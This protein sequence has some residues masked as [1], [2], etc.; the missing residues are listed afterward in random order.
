MTCQI[1]FFS[2][3]KDCVGTAEMTW[4]LEAPMSVGE[5]YSHLTEKFPPLAK[6]RPSLLMAVNQA[7][8]S[9]DALVSPG[10]E[11]AFMPPVQG[12]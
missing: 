1:L 7:Y 6:W 8:V 2:T 11:V 10:D 3:L 5:L 4:P 9:V 12:G